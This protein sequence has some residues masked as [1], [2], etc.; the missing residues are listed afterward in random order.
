MTTPPIQKSIYT[1][2]NRY[3]PIYFVKVLTQF[4]SFLHSVLFLIN[5]QKS[6]YVLC[7]SNIKYNYKGKKIFH[8]SF[9]LFPIVTWMITQDFFTKKR[10]IDM[11]IY[12]CGSYTFMPEHVLNG[13]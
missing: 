7:L 10:T 13:T 6:F 2:I 4:L 11:H 9:V 1:F 3:L 8:I 12:F 5:A